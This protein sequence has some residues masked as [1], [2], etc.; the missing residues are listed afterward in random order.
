MVDAWAS[1]KMSGWEMGHSRRPGAAQVRDSKQTL[2]HLHRGAC[3][4]EKSESVALGDFLET[5]LARYD[6]CFEAAIA[7]IGS[8]QG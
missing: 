2:N 4:N 6:D 3:M 8:E 5:V 1:V 7:M